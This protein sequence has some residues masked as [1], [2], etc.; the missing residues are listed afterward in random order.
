M[1]ILQLGIE[2]IRNVSRS[3]VMPDLKA[4]GLVASIK[5][6]VEDLHF[7]KLFNIGFVYSNLSDIESLGQDKKVALYRI[8]QEQTKNII[9][10]SQAKNI[11]ISLYRSSDQVRMLIKDDGIGFDPENTR[12]GLGLSNICE[13]TRLSNGNAVLSAAP[14]KGCSI[15]INIPIESSN[16][17]LNP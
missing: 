8:V 9:K 14:G 17:Q 12:R 10:Y 15:I 5:E 4:G 1:E 2:E 7:T 11:E 3:M 13:R 16:R 6:L